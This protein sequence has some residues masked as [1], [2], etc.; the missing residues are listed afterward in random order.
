MH[1]LRQGG[2][3]RADEVSA[4]FMEAGLV[5]ALVEIVSTSQ[6]GSLLEEAAD[7]L[8]RLAFDSAL[9]SDAITAAEGVPPLVQLMRSA[10]VDLQG[11]A[12]NCLVNIS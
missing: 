6:N 1:T 10:S 2:V 7:C 11:A 12:L 9:R 5:A 8:S 3:E 4:P